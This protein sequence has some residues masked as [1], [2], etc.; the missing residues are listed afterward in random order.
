MNCPKFG[1]EITD[2]LKQSY[3]RNCEGCV[4]AKPQFQLGKVDIFELARRLK[5][6]KENESSISDSQD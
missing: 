4:F 6:K 2:L 3:C 1:F 5:E